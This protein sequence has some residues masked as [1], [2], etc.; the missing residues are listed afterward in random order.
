MSQQAAADLC[1]V[2]TNVCMLQN[3]VLH[4]QG[5]SWE[6]VAAVCRYQPE[7]CDCMVLLM[8]ALAAQH[9][10]DHAAEFWDI[11]CVDAQTDSYE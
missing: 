2:L 4:Y 10:L 9:I 7:S 1:D 8:R 3:L 6:D 5:S 11:I